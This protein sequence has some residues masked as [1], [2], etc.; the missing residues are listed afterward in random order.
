M[1]SQFALTASKIAVQRMGWSPDQFWSSTIEDFF[2]AID[3][4]MSSS[5]WSP[6][7][8]NLVSQLKERFPDD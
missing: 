5:A 6:V 7:D 3:M 8:A 2:S 4:E 1:F